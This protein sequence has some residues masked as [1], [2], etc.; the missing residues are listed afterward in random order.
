VCTHLSA[1]PAFGAGKLSYADG[2]VYQGTLVTDRKHGVGTQTSSDGG[3]IFVGTFAND[4]RQGLG[5]TFWGGRC[6]CVGCM[7][8]Q[9]QAEHS[10]PACQRNRMT[11]S[12]G[13]LRLPH[14]HR[15]KKLVAEYVDDAPRCGNM[16][17]LDD[18]TI[19]P[20]PSQALRQAIAAARIR[21]AAQG[22]A[23]AGNCS[24]PQMPGLTLAQ[25][26][27]VSCLHV[28]LM[29]PCVLAAQA[30]PAASPEASATQA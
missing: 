21:A 9:Q 27:R 15:C 18:D 23:A 14:T 10:M 26:S 12:P 20:P 29:P 25:P 11:H 8:Q 22:A 5:V 1:P 19:E 24:L 6:V 13:V 7:L 4:L 2:S 16:L 28:C 17:D 30:T 3:S